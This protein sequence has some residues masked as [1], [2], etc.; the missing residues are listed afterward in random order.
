ME[1]IPCGISLKN[2]QLESIYSNKNYMRDFGIPLGCSCYNTSIFKCYENN[3]CPVLKS[4]S[5]TTIHFC[6]YAATK[7]SGEKLQ[8]WI[9][10][11]P[12]M[13]EKTAKGEPEIIL[14]LIISADSIK[15]C[16][17]QMAAMGQSVAYISHAIK[18][19]LEGLHGGG[20]VI[21]VGITDGDLVLIEQGWSIVKNNISDI[22]IIAQNI[23]YSSTRKTMK[24]EKIHPGYIV[25]KAVDLL[26]SKAMSKGISLREDVDPLLP[27]A[28]LDHFSVKRMLL[29]MILNAIEACIR[30]NKTIPHQVIVRAETHSATHFKFEIEDNGIGMDEQE[31]GKIF[32]E[33]Y[34]TRGTRGTGLGLSVV[35]KIAEA[36]QGK[37]EVESIQGKGSL[38]RIIL[39]VQ[40]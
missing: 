4:F 1:L 7:Q 21:D 30:D 38:F 5:D 23:L 40:S 8:V 35:E 24:K 17:S 22:S 10:A 13:D 20:E 39:N 19:I 15:G 29:N 3:N 2:K 14:E 25:K 33:F 37:I 9:C 27:E 34:S 31:L 26:K 28:E 11:V 12:I 16:Q 32:N 36:H 6:D 18:N